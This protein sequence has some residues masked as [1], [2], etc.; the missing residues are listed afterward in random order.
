MLPLHIGSAVSA[1]LDDRV[2]PFFTLTANSDLWH[3]LAGVAMVKRDS[4]V[5]YTTL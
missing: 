5:P 3:V 4:V 1:D 2:T